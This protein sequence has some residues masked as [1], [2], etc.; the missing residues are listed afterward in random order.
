MSDRADQ[1]HTLHDWDDA[2]A[3]GVPSM[4]LTSSVQVPNST[5]TNLL[6][7][8]TT[9]TIPSTIKTVHL[10]ASTNEKQEATEPAQMPLSNHDFCMVIDS[11]F[12]AEECDELIQCSQA[13]GY[14]SIEKEYL[15]EY[16][17]SERVLVLSKKLATILWQRLM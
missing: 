10:L 9:I 4:L 11:V 6:L 1:H 5:R 16:R 8:N 15:K 12:T 17:S 7:P 13:L 3:S 14:Q 2:C